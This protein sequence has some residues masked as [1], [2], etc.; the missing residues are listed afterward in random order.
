M[1]QK[2]HPCTVRSLEYTG[3]NVVIVTLVPVQGTVFDFEPGQFAML[4]LYENGKPWRQ[5]AYSMASSP[6]T[7]DHI[8]FGIKVEGEFTQH[9]EKLKT[10]DSLD[11]IGPYGV[12]TLRPD[13]NEIVFLAGGIGITPFLSI[14]RY[15]TEMR[16]S[17]KLTLLYANRTKDDIAFFDE[18]LA[19]AEQNR[20]LTLMFAV[21]AGP[22]PSYTECCE[23]RITVEVMKQYCPTF[24]GKQFFLCGPPPF[25]DAMLVCLTEQGVG[26][27][28]IKMEKFGSGREKP[29]TG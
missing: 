18:L 6:H 12:F 4:R 11:V 3:N 17:R 25:M 14:L 20:N 21:E 9:V 29:L 27:D 10:G 23:G 7:N 28:M 26:R 5:K 24:V 1:E 19:L 22:K 16:S 8:Q 15:E 13:M 2:T